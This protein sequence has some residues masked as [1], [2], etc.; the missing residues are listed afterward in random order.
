[1]R[2]PRLPTD[3]PRA[4]ARA[5]L[6]FGQK[7]DGGRFTISRRHNWATRA[8]PTLLGVGL[9]GV[10]AALAGAPLGH[11]T[12]FIAAASSPEECPAR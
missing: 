6:G 10:I 12:L 7:V 4:G 5:R 2:R 3:S 8:P 11:T 1:M 9:F